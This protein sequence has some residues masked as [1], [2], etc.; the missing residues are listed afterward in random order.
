VSK[1]PIGRYPFG[2]T[3]V[4]F[5]VAFLVGVGLCG[6]DYLL[7]A[8]GIGKSTEEF[9]VGILD[10]PSLIIMFLSAA[11]LIFTLIAWM[12]ASIVSSTASIGSEDD[13]HRSLTLTDKV[14]QSE[15]RVSQADDTTIE[16]I[17]E[18]SRRKLDD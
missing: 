2:K 6:L 5:A 15:D 4:I 18:S 17:E 11:C 7:A 9:G 14:S 13:K 1:L 16:K 8:N 10:A 3:V 12:I